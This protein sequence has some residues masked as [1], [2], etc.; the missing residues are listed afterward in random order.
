MQ[1]QIWKKR[2]QIITI[3]IIIIIIVLVRYRWNAFSNLVHNI[4]LSPLT[5][6]IH[7]SNKNKMQKTTPLRNSHTSTSDLLTWSEQP[8]PQSSPAASG[9][10]SRQVTTV[11]NSFLFRKICFSIAFGLFNSICREIC[12][13]SVLFVCSSIR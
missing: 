7:H 9:H 2:I 12:I 3:I 1:L 13:M 6:F 8:P 5:H 10:R 4:T 11:A